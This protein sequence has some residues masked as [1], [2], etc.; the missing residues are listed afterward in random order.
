MKV[1]DLV[2]ICW[3]CGPDSKIGLVIHAH[4]QYTPIEF[5]VRWVNQGADN[6]IVS[7]MSEEQVEIIN[8][9]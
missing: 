8:E 5:D 6:H 1:G 4:E 3:R 2:K 7:R 9:S